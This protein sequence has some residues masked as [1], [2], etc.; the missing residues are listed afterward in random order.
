MEADGDKAG[1]G[2]MPQRPTIL[3][4][5][6]EPSALER[7]AA[8]LR[9]RYGEDYRVLC[10]RSATDALAEL[11]RMREAG[12]SL[13]LVLAEQWTPG[14]EGSAV[15]AQ[16]RELH[17]HAKRGL[18]IKW[19][20]W[21]HR[22]TAEAIFAA[23]GRG[24]I[25]YYVLKPAQIGDEQFHRTVSEFLHEWSRSQATTSSGITVV[26]GDL[27]AR[28]Y[29]LRDLLTRNGI[30]HCFRARESEE[31]S[32]LLSE[33]GREGS[34]EPVVIF[35][36]GPVLV[37]PSDVELAAGFGVDTDLGPEREFDVVVVG[38]GP[39]GLTTAV[40]AA[41]EGLRTLVVERESIGGQAG[42]SSL[43]RNYL[44]F[45]RGVSGSELAQRAYQ[46]AWVFGSKFLLMR[47]VIDLRADADGLELEIDG[48]DRV[49][50]ATVVLATGVTYRRLEIPALERLTGI[51]VFYGGSTSEARELAD[52]DLFVVGGGNSAGQAAMHLSRY[53]RSVTVLV[54]RQS[55]LATMS[56]YLVEALEVA[57]NVEV[58]SSTEVVGGTEKDGWLDT[59][60]LR[61]CESGERETVDAGGLFLMIG[62]R[63]H[64]EWMPPAIE[65]DDGGY[66]LT[67]SELI[68]SGEMAESWP[69]ER[70]P[71]AMET[72][73]PG[74]FAV[75]DVRS[76][77]TQR[78]ASAVGDGSVV[79]SQLHRLL[80]GTATAAEPEAREGVGQPR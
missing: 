39:A 31:G 14:I 18:L 60:E 12:E 62:A 78:V 1:R 8:E 69:L 13:A 74:V 55:L 35:R 51:G 47:E 37:D 73:M 42:S 75:G 57:E 16:V 10:Q 53:A 77:A 36:D 30:P 4:I 7:I 25:D 70:P 38:A 46:Q 63:P 59:L 3:A 33:I 56:R 58:R 6:D 26:A 68:Q 50:T 9:R 80:A 79:V 15:L 19:G 28:G 23:M 72:S 76:G 40:Y 54:R 20:G 65:R 22:P 24:D 61:D 48:C 41:S 45:S 44:G 29:E 32:R 43:I 17:P 67:G 2:V 5:D 11:K 21:G 52:H 71:L 66:L 64:T 49:R 34:D 27:S